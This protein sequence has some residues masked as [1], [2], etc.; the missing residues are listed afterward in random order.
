[1]VNALD[2]MTDGGHVVVQ[3]GAEAEGGGIAVADDGPGMPPEVESRGF[4]PFSRPRP[5]VPGSASRL[6]MPSASAIGASSPW[7]PLPGEARGSGCGFLPRD[8]LFHQRKASPILLYTAS[9]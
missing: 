9:M 7:K 1:V 6:S 3:T 8:C 5:K 4:E 2:A